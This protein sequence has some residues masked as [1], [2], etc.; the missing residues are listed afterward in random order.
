MCGPVS[1]SLSTVQWLSLL[2]LTPFPK[3]VEAFETPK[4]TL[5]ISNNACET[6]TEGLKINAE[7]VQEG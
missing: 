1:S 7:S 2:S 3:G 6:S 4:N 5:E